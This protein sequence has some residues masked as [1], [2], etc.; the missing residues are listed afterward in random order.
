MRA[1]ACLALAAVA[2]VLAASA[3][4]ETYKWRV[5]G[6][7]TGTYSSSHSWVSCRDSAVAGVSSI[8]EHVDV[9]AKLRPRGNSSY[10]PGNH[11]FG[12]SL[13]FGASGGWHLSGT[14]RPQQEDPITGELVCGAPLPVDCGGAVAL[15][16]GTSLSLTAV[17]RGR[18]FLAGYQFGHFWGAS[19]SDS[20]LGVCAVGDPQLGEEVSGRFGAAFGS[21][22]TRSR[23][24]FPV[25]RLTRGESFSVTGT[26]AL[27]DPDACARSSS[28]RARSRAGSC[29]GSPSSRRAGFPPTPG[30]RTRCCA[31]AGCALTA[32]ARPARADRLL[33]LDLPAGG[34]HRPSGA[35]RALGGG[36]ADAGAH[37]P[38]RRLQ[39]R[40]RRQDGQG[41]QGPAALHDKGNAHREGRRRNRQRHDHNHGRA[42]RL[43]DAGGGP[44]ARALQEVGPAAAWLAGW[45]DLRP[46]YSRLRRRGALDSRLVLCPSRTG[47]AGSARRTRSTWSTIRRART[48]ATGTSSRDPSSRSAG[49]ARERLPLRRRRRPAAVARPRS[50]TRRTGTPASRSTTSSATSRTTRGREGRACRGAATP[51][52]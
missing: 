5:S 4:A 28:Q 27:P 16:R 52:R 14:Y 36:R 20:P 9:R 49:A 18:A 44:Q 13:R 2:L 6:S 29:E 10:A 38:G 37:G 45:V 21:E 15:E 11:L 22:N 25:A 31:G 42:A 19:P 26:P 33:P 48:T 47:T 41:A 12:T 7:V 24:E 8:Q 39:D 32:R 34:T 43:E 1:W 46:Q 50:S 30:G 40:Q 17:K 3:T 35:A 23:I 51:R